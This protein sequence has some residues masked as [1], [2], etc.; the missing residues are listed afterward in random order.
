MAK[1]ATRWQG[2]GSTKYPWDE[3]LDGRMWIL[4]PGVDF[5]GN[6]HNMRNAA[7]FVAKYRNLR[8]RVATPADGTVHVQCLGRRIEDDEEVEQL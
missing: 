6:V 4:E 7:Y 1:T 2:R 8:V 5:D 3:W